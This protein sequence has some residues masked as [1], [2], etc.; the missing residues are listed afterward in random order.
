MIRDEEQKAQELE[1]EIAL[2]QSKGQLGLQNGPPLQQRAQI[3]DL[4]IPQRGHAIPHATAFQGVNYLD[5]RSPLTP[6]LQVTPW[7]ANFR[8]GTYPKYN[9]S[10]DPA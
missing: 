6:H 2:M 3:E 9:G 10:T 1:Q 4:F 8:A 7:P 5:E